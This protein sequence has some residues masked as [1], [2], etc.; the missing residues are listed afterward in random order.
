MWLDSKFPPKTAQIGWIHGFFGDIFWL[1]LFFCWL[2]ADRK[3]D[4]KE[5]YNTKKC[6]RYYNFLGKGSKEGAR[7]LRKRGGDVGCG[8]VRQRNLSVLYRVTIQ[9]DS[10]LPLTSKH[11]F[12]FSIR[13]MPMY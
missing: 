13:P 8:P 7:R 12:R 2:A 3:L 11:K 4:I 9:V 10:N 1:H 5:K 6:I